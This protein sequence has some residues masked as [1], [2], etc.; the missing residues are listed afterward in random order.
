MFTMTICNN[1]LK[2]YKL[3]WYGYNGERYYISKTRTLH[4]VSLQDVKNKAMA[5]FGS[6]PDNIQRI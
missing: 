5:L 4:S 2:R 6:K 3:Q 1:I